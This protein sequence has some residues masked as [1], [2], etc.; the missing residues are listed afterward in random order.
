M[1][2][3]VENPHDSLLFY[4]ERGQLFSWLCYDY[5]SLFAYEIAAVA[6][7]SLKPGRLGFIVQAE[8]ADI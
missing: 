4:D 8:D 3:Y 5:S 2:A 1:I 6:F 7:A